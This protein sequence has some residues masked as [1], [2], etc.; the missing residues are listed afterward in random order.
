VRKLFEAVPWTAVRPAQELV[1]QTSDDPLRFVSCAATA[2]RKTVVAY[3]P[4]GAKADVLPPVAK[5]TP[6]TWCDP[7]TGE[8]KVGGLA[9]PDARDWVLIIRVK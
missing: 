9:P 5:T 6:A 8:S 2:D 1:K 3:F 7:R 4:A